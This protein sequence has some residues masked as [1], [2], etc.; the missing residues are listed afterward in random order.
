MTPTD[1]P[2]S[3]PTATVDCASSEAGT[4]CNDGNACTGPDTCQ[5]GTCTGTATI[6]ADNPFPAPCTT[7]AFTCDPATGRCVPQLLADGTACN[8]GSACSTGDTCQAGVCKPSSVIVC[9]DTLIPA[10]CNTVHFDCNPANAQCEARPVI[11]GTACNDGDTCTSSDSCQ[12]GVCKG[13]P[14]AEGQACCSQQL[15]CVDLGSDSANCGSCGHQCMNSVCLQGQCYD[16]CVI[17]GVGYP[18]GTRNPANDC[19]QCDTSKSRTAWSTLGLPGQPG[20]FCALGCGS[21]QCFSGSCMPVSTT[22]G[23]PNKACATGVCGNS[24]CEYTAA[25]EGGACTVPLSTSGCGATTGTC[26]SGQCVPS[27]ANEGGV[28]QVTDLSANDCKTLVGTCSS[29]N[30]A[31]SNRPDGT[32]CHGGQG[33]CKVGSCSNGQCLNVAPVTCP[34]LPAACGAAQATCNASTG[35]CVYPTPAAGYPG[36]GAIDCTKSDLSGRD[37]SKCCPG[38]V[39]VCPPIPGSAGFPKFCFDFECWAPSDLP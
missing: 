28:C 18:N 21:G 6:C 33:L 26:Q 37:P 20:A 39:C 14:C 7:G 27:V 32:V 29:G 24:G 11:D 22:G 35:Q 36:H 19:Q 12:A 1:T 38:Q 5:A 31:G 16:G 15:G 17:A 8:D 25:N 3:S 9:P 30:C 4:P 10:Q 23:C 2:T 13:A 34:Q